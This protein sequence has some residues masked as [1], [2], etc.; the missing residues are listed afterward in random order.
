MYSSETWGSNFHDID[1]IHRSGIKT[2]L[3]VRQNVNNEIVYIE[4]N[5]FPFI[6]KIKKRQLKF[7]RNINEYIEIY[8]ESAIKKMLHAGTQANVK[9]LKYYETLAR[10]HHAK[11]HYK[12][13]I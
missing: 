2:A 8:P 11:Y 3:G 12:T 9:Y 7:W 6:C 1:Y 13:I 5:T 4:S 10:N